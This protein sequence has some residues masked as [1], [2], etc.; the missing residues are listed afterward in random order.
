L[1][2]KW[3]EGVSVVPSDHNPF[4]VH[5]SVMEKATLCRLPSKDDAGC[6]CKARAEAAAGPDG[7]VVGAAAMSGMAAVACASCC[8]LP[9]TLPAVIL[10]SLGGAITV[11]DH[12]HIWVTRGAIGAVACGWGWL[13][14]QLARNRKKPMRSTVLTMLFATTL[15]AA[16]ASWPLIEPVAFHA[17]GIV[18][19]HAVLRSD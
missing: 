8:I 15:A 3:L 14:W 10:T 16:A 12:A 17:L 13:V 7:K 4:E 6:G 2:L 18:K 11:L 5:M 19:K 9:F 1:N